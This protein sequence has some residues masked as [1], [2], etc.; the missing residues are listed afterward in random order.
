MYGSVAG[1]IRPIFDGFPEAW[2]RAEEEGAAGRW[3]AF[4]SNPQHGA[5]IQ[6]NGQN[7]VLQMDALGE[8]R[9]DECLRRAQEKAA[10]DRERRQVAK[11]TQAAQYWKAAAA[12]WRLDR[13]A[14]EATQ[15]GD[16]AA[17]AAFKAQ[18]AQK[19]QE[20]TESFNRLPPGWAR[21]RYTAQRQFPR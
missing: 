4:S 5:V 1:E 20:A 18:A 12:Y 11:L 15:K 16:N 8:K 17:A 6:P 14:S 21:G 10:N 7:I 19:A 2:R 9:L 3:P 13:Q